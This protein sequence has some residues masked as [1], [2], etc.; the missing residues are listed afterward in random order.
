MKKV[1]LLTVVMVLMPCLA[2]GHPASFADLVDAQKNAVVNISTT[3]VARS[4]PIP[5]MPLD[6]FK[7]LFNHQMPTPSPREKHALGSGFIISEDGYVVTNN[8]VVEQADKIVVKTAEGKEYKARLVGRDAKLDVALLKID[9][10]GLDKVVFEP[11]EKLRVGDWVISIGNPFGLEQTVTAGIV[12]AKGRVIGAG[13]YD[14]FI[15]TDA[16]IN[17]GNSGGPLFNTNGEVVGINTAIYSRSGGSNG[18][19]F[20]IPIQLALPVIEDLRTTGHVERARLGVTI[21]AV[22]KDVMQ[23]LG[24][25]DQKGALI[26]QIAAGS[27]AARVGIEPGDVIIKVDEHP[28]QRV[29]DLPIRIASHKPGDKVDLLLIRQGREI[30]LSARVEA[31]DD[32]QSSAQVESRASSLGIKGRTMIASDIRILATRVQQGVVVEDVVMGS[33]A[34]R[35]GLVKGDVIYSMAGQPIRHLKDFQ[36]ILTHFKKGQAVQCMIDRH[37]SQVFTILRV[38][39]D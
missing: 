30:K 15:Q 39:S 10:K 23:A 1:F 28:I 6:F 26:R 38:V 20:A 22:S 34:Q 19:G 31:M 14:H 33:S 2:W 32:E 37:G 9:A 5:G 35:S 11:S 18:I 4:S 29:S 17:P 12:S 25:K 13:P 36:K 16:A 27:A 7:D 8:H 21:D 24:L 3:Q